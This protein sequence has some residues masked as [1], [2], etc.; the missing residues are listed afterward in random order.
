[1]E[2]IKNKRDFTLGLLWFV[3]SLFPLAGLYNITTLTVYTIIL[4]VFHT[5]GFIFL[6]EKSFKCWGFIKG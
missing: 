4:G 1:M 5:Y 2:N 6:V 3:C